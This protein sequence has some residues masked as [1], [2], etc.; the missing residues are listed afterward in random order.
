MFLEYYLLLLYYHSLRVLE[1]SIFMFLEKSQKRGNVVNVVT[2]G[3]FIKANMCGK[4][5]GYNTKLFMY[6]LLYRIKV[7]VI[8]THSSRLYKDTKVL[9]TEQM[10]KR[11]LTYHKLYFYQGM[12][13]TESVRI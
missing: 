12:N 5:T 2:L 13:C 8:Y 9:I 6:V 1:M 4:T 10:K 7:K 3:S 11:H